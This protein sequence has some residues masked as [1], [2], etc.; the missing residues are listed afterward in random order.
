MT[1]PLQKYQPMADV[2][3]AWRSPAER[4]DQL[5]PAV[6]NLQL[7]ELQTSCSF[8]ELCISSNK[9]IKLLKYSSASLRL[10]QYYCFSE[11]I[12]ICF[13][14]MIKFNHK[15]ESALSACAGDQ[16]AQG[17]TQA[18]PF[19]VQQSSVSTKERSQDTVSK[20]LIVFNLH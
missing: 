19:Y 7:L 11:K 20:K 10:Q 8:P 4:T 3:R 9:R 16:R 13:Y 15:M 6:R 5:F 18:A 12:N 14:S 17:S 1:D 2:L